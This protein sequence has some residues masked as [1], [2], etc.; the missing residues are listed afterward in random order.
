MDRFY[1]GLH[2]PSDAQHFERCCIHIN[3]LTARQKPLGCEE[4]LIDSQAFKTLELRGDYPHSPRAYAE[5][6]HRV[7]DAGLAGEIIAVS[8]DYMCEDYIFQQ[9]YKLTG[10]RYTIADHQR[11]TIER[12]EA[13]RAVLR[14]NIYLMP[15]LQGY[16]PDEY[17]RHLDM[18]GDLLPRG[19]WVGV[20]SV[21]KRNADPGAIRDVLY[22]IKKARS[23]LRTHGFGL[24]RSAI[25]HP[26]VR[27]LL[28]S[29]DSVAWSFAARKQG[30]NAND[31]REA[32]RFG[33]QVEGIDLSDL[34][35]FGEPPPGAGGAK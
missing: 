27:S 29:A 26:V 8:Q 6:V 3:R 17:V 21:C 11:L 14:P 16:R 2:Q 15:V 7:A 34:P 33:R 4:V 28:Y 13:I 12:Y 10:R 32:E 1:I 25:A 19:A 35:M 23:D 5:Q 30:R 24:K 22:A 18:Y 9:R 31:W 20:G